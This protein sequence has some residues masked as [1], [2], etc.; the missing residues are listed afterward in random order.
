MTDRLHLYSQVLPQFDQTIV[1]MWR[2]VLWCQDF[3]NNFIPLM[4]MVDWNHDSFQDSIERVS[5]DD[6]DL[7]DQESFFLAL[8]HL[9]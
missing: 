6:N 5:L 3:P 8:N 1:S 2:L 4:S 7:N 9:R